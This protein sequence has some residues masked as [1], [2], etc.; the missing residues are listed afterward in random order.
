MTDRC[1]SGQWLQYLGDT[2]SGSWPTVAPDLHDARPDE[3]HHTRRLP[4]FSSRPRLATAPDGEHKGIE[5]VLVASGLVQVTIAGDIPLIR[6]G[7]VALA[8]PAHVTG[9]R[10]LVNE[11]ALLYGVLR[12]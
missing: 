7:D 9:W 1:G 10:N 3:V 2:G 12:G 11:P 8:T 4:P 5:L 6:A